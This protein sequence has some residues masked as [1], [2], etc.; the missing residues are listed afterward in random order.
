M[1][2]RLRLYPAPVTFVSFAV[3]L[4]LAVV[5]VI[6]FGGSPAHA[7]SLKCGDTI[8]AD[9][10]LHKDLV[11][12]PN[13]GL[14]IGANGIMLNLNGHTIDGDGTPTP[15]AHCDPMTEFCDVGVVNFG[16]DGVTVMHGS[17]RQFE[18]G[19]NFGE[20]RHNRLL[21]ISASGNGS[22]GIQLF[23]CSRSLIR[24]SS[25]SGSTEPEVGTG[26]G[27]FGCDHV[28]ILNSTFRHNALNGLMTEESAHG[29]VKGNVVSRNGGEA[30]L[31][32]TG[33][34]FR[35][36]HNR[37]L[38]NGDGIN[39]GPG[40]DNAVTRNRVLGGRDGIRIEHGRGN[41]VAHNLVAHARRAGIRLGLK[42]RFG[43]AHNLVRRNRV[44]DSRVDG[45]VVAKT[46]HHSLLEGNVA[47]GSGDDGFDVESGST[48]L[49]RNRAAHNGDLGIDAVLGVNDGG[50]NIAHNNGDPRQCRNIAC[51]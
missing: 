28:R 35:I 22:V 50:G 8:T 3:V 27:L 25:G 41:L 44:H 51:S 31:M 30:I 32:E 10:T 39:L 40:T 16:H 1:S 42:H 36:S 19:V 43:G 34:G 24:N 14:L 49:T 7:A 23:N 4:A 45:F 2:A 48:T 15:P 20:V 18:G 46:D 47:K 17:V 9:T 5:G 38:R 13:N 12:C 11:N 6:G 33:K 29:L 26:L 21:D 37:L